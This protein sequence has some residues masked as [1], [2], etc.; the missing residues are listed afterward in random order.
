MIATSTHII[1]SIIIFLTLA[2][3][4]AAA[5]DELPRELTTLLKEAEVAVVVRVYVDENGKADRDVTAILKGTK[6]RFAEIFPRIVMPAVPTGSSCKQ[7]IFYRS[8]P[9]SGLD[10]GGWV[11]SSFLV[12]AEQCIQVKTGKGM[13]KV[14]LAQIFGFL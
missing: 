6:S 4:S 5:S 2:V 3:G 1:P 13:E 9:S 7:L 11:Y 8:N 12:D 14:S 10:F